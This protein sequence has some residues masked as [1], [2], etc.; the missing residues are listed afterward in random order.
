MQD[1]L[2]ALA[3]GAPTSPARIYIE[4]YLGEDA[5]PV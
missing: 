1:Y 2:S 3:S 4:A 5:A